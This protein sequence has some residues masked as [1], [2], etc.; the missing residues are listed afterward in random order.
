L[1]PSHLN[2]YLLSLSSDA[3]VA[4]YS[5]DELKHILENGPNDSA[6]GFGPIQIESIDLAPSHLIP[7]EEQISRIHQR[8]PSETYKNL[9]RT[10]RVNF[11]IRPKSACKS[12]ANL[13]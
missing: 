10:W 12:P 3:A 11:L 1:G 2:K 13:G 9:Y 6:H 4:P 7:I 5:P 8:T